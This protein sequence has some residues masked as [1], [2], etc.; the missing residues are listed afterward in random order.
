MASLIE[1]DCVAN[2]TKT[3]TSDGQV[4]VRAAVPINRGDRIA[5]SYTEPMWGTINRQR[6]LQQTKFFQCRCQRCQDPTELDTFTSGIY[7]LQC[8]LREQGV[9]LAEDPF[10]ET[11]DWV[12]NKCSAR[13]PASFIASII[14]TVG[15][16]L[17]GLKRGSITDCEAFIRK[18]TKVLHPHHFYL[19][20]VKMALCQMYGHLE[21]QNLTDMSGTFRA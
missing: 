18:Y 1:H 16:E 11:S 4:V 15:K 3:F 17:V 6:H 7:C 13:Q 5:L 21:G 20:D 8:G 9:L 10:S 2:A 12:C 19:T 14:E